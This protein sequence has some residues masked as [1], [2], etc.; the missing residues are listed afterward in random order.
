ML[1]KI[2]SSDLNCQKYKSYYYTEKE[3]ITLEY[4]S[5]NY[6][7]ITTDDMKNGDGLRVVLWV[8]GCS[9]HCKNCHNPVTWD[10]NGGIPF[11]DDTF[12]ELI[13]DLDHDYI[14]GLTLSGGDPLYPD[15][16]YVVSQVVRLKHAF[17]DKTIWI[18]TGYVWEDLIQDKK[19]LDILK[20][21]DVLVDGEYV[22]ALKDPKYEW[23]GSTNQRVIDVQRSL[24]EGKVVLHERHKEFSCHQKGRH[25]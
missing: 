18:Y 5:M 9:H 12:K 10:P 25:C 16:L 21:T 24:A 3:V 19:I 22:E 15:N 20:L 7:N 4:H 2:E 11:T 8:A 17:P 1:S 13:D 6:H 23:A 14:S